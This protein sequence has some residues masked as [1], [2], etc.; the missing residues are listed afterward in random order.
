MT[1]RKHCI[2]S[3]CELTSLHGFK[4]IP[5]TNKYKS[6]LWCIVCVLSGLFCC[7]LIY[8]QLNR[9]HMKRINTSIETIGYPVWEVDFP[10]VTI[11]N[12]NAVCKNKTEKFKKIL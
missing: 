10:A 12:V 4:Y 6:C 7:Y 9:Y 11:C 5:T 2:S 1:R 8:L 3:F